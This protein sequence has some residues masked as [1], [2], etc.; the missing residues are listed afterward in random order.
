MKNIIVLLLISFFCSCD[1]IREVL[2]G[3]DKVYSLSSDCGKI[4]LRA[5]VFASRTLNL[6][7]DFTD[8]NLEMDVAG[9]KNAIR[10]DTS[11]PI[12][13]IYQG[14]GKGYKIKVAQMKIQKNKSLCI[15]MQFVYPLK[16][17][18]VITFLPNRYL[19]CP[20][21]NFVNDSILIRI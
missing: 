11:N 16:R 3:S 7:E 18:Q 4:E 12:R 1:S 6:L 14:D 5:S 21:S 8:C 17:G 20:N 15:K 19:K 10:A 2:V 9:V 13:E